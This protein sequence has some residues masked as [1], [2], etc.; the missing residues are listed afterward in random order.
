[1]ELNEN[2]YA[3]NAISYEGETNGDGT[4]TT[5]SATIGNTISSDHIYYT[6][7]DN[8]DDA[9]TDH[10]DLVKAEDCIENIISYILLP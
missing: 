2:L 6:S 10:T 3:E 8:D 1:M 5:Y 4:V 9:V 7:N